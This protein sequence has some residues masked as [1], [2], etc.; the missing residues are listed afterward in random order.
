[1]FTG[2]EDLTIVTPSKWLA[3]NVSQSF[4]KDYKITVIPNGINTNLF[5]PNIN[6][7]KE[8][9]GILNKVMLLGVASIWDQRKGL[10]VFLELAKKL[11]DNYAIVIIGLSKR[12]IDALPKRI[13]GV[14]FTNG[15]QELAEYYSAA[16]YFINPTFED[17]Y[18]T[19]N[20]EAISCGTPVIS[21]NT[22]GSVESALLYG[23]VTKE[24]TAESIYEILIKKELPNCKIDRKILD[25]KTFVSR[26]M[27]L[28]DRTLV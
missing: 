19:T 4:L 13:Y 25:V 1:M 27:K 28:Y 14:E 21:F 7:I 26:Y 24:K 3:K 6:N 20:L 2:I 18:P 11:D 9:L 12:Q 22:G 10:K 5:K 15:I 8:K 17:N 23:Y 16:D